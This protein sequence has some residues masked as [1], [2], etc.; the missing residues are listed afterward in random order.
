MIRVTLYQALSNLVLI[1]GYH[2]IDT[3]EAETILKGATK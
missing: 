1:A 3:T 2:G